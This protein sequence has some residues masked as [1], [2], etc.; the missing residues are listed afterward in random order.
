MINAEA[1]RETVVTKRSPRDVG[2]TAVEFAGRTVEARPWASF[3]CLLLVYLCAELGYS[4]STPLWHDE[5]FTFYIAQA[6][7]LPAVFAEIRS[8]DLNPPLSYLLTRAS[9]HAFG[10]GTLQCRLPEILGFALALLG[11]FHFVRYRA[12]SAFGL[13]AAGLLFGSRA[14]ELVMQARPYGLML[15]MSALAF[16][17]WQVS[18]REI[19]RRFP[20]PELGLFAFLFALLLTHIFGLFA[21]AALGVA[22]AVQIAARRRASMRRLFALL[23]PLT[24]TLLYLPLLRNHARSAFPAAFQPSGA[25]VFLFYMGHVDRELISLSL[26]AVAIAVVCG[27]AWLRGSVRFALTTPEWVG[28]AAFTASPLILIADLMVSHG[29]FFDRYGVIA[30]LG[31][32]ILFAVI[33]CWWTGGRSG[34]AVVAVLVSLL[35]TQRLPNAAGAVASAAIFRHTEPRVVPINTA[36][37]TDRTLPLVTAS[38]LTFLEMQRRESPALLRRTFY[39]TDPEAAIEEAHATIFES[40][41]EEARLFPVTGSVMPYRQF[42]QQHPSFYVLGTYDYPEDWLLRTLQRDGA[43]LTMLGRL[44]G[45][46]KDH[47]L[48]L[49]SS[50][51][52]TR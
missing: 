23:L 26:A 34:A 42:L 4:L 32:A 30:C 49:V 38:G 31:T 21:W 33:F 7:N 40:M 5:L 6:R 52:N 14:G 10:V 48:Y 9:F 37:L 1:D 3:A 13:L 11:V 27:R 15:G 16:A 19:R 45:S 44:Q 35:V 51:A 8:V 41:P 36:L 18:S 22:E 50:P 39:L 28:S 25:D 2:R 12:G 46:Y 17:C 24:G 47:E 20:L 29:A 43:V